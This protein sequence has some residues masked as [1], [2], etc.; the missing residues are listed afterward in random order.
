MSVVLM[1][2]ASGALG[3]P[4]R[5]RLLA[6]GH[7]VRQLVR[8]APRAGHEIGWNPHRD[9]LP[10]AALE[11]VDAV[12]NLAGAG[13][14]DRP[15]TRSRKAELVTSRV[16][17]A[18]TLVD[19]LLRHRV[20]HGRAPRLLQGTAIG[21]YGTTSGAVPYDES[22]P[23][24]TDFV[25]QLVRRWEQPLEVG[26][27]EGLSVVTARTAIVLDADTGPVP[28]MRLPFLL[29]LGATFGD[30]HQHLAAIGSRDWLR[31]MEWLLD[32]PD[33]DGV[34]NLTLPEPAT[35]GELSDTVA[36]LLNRPRL[37]AVPA[38]VLR[39][40]L[41]G[42]SDLLLGDQYVVPARLLEQGFRF[43]DPDLASA[44]RRALARTAGPPPAGA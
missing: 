32:S 40:A 8:R 34:Y 16:N 4:L 37:L 3:T 35:S 19:G 29:G 7:T 10:A 38:P 26:R 18:R 23:A 15:W 28:L 12:V 6:S 5:N 1:A 33:A 39:V 2:G 22:A 11:G 17:P 36:R 43:D 44:L 41:R 13:I 21:W 42:M 9:R 27:A 30:G 31:A 20:E 14:A 25:A 24:G